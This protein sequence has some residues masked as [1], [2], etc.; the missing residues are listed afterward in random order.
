[1]QR[2]TPLRYPGGKG[3][4]APFIKEVFKYNGLL[5]RTYVEPYAGGAA[6][7]MSLLL[8]GYA[9]QIVINDIDPLVYSFWWSA[10][11]D[12]DE[13]LRRIIDTDVSIDVWMLQKEVITNA[14]NHAITDVGFATFFL[15][16]TNRSGILHAGVIGGKRQ[17]GN[18]KIDARFNKDDLVKRIEL[19]GSHS[20][21]VQLHN[22]D[23][24]DFI[25]KIIPQ[26][27]GEF[28]VYFDPPYFNKGSLLYQNYYSYED[29]GK[30]ASEIRSLDA[31]WIVTYDNV[32]EI[33][34]LYSGE[35]FAE[36]DISYSAHLGRPRGK[37]V[38]F[39]KNI[40][41]PTLPY[42]RN[43]KDQS[44]QQLLYSAY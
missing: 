41:L 1:M 5:D 18:Y 24:L 39:Y 9:W 35:K 30:I 20:G 10:L 22:L 32:P 8:E 44:G 11:N 13:L 19:I 42:T 34:G 31:P 12:T 17:D 14:K 38:L 25:K 15:N 16:R 37:E 40:N 26:I 36:F 21:R 27:R 23:A 33:V 2:F 6:V 3:K 28:L 43:F 4:L 29:H 7:A